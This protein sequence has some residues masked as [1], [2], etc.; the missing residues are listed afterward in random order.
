MDHVLKF[1]DLLCNGI[2]KSLKEHV[3]V[4]NTVFLVDR[5]ETYRASNALRE[6]G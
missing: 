4:C 2:L 5:T 6:A 1:G 3:F